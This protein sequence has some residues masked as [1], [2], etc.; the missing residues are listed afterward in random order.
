MVLGLTVAALATVLTHKLNNAIKKYYVE[1]YSN[2]KCVGKIRSTKL[3]LVQ[4][5][6][7]Y[8]I[9]NDAV[10]KA[11]SINNEV[12]YVKQLR[13]SKH[14]KMYHCGD[15]LYCRKNLN[16]LIHDGRLIHVIVSLA[17]LPALASY[18]YAIH[19]YFF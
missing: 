13:G 18:V 17:K 8:I 7:K 15:S 3:V 5:K 6:G 9:H 2:P 1:M 10:I 19:Y 11:T 12:F 4:H 14:K 16:K